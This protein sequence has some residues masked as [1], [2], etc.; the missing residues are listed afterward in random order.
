VSPDLERLVG[1]AIL[2]KEF[3]KRLLDNPDTAV[4]DGGFN[5]TPAELDQVREAIKDRNTR[6]DQLDQELDEVARGSS[7]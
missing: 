7:W 3:R 2:D 1:R 4:K 5:L 6:R